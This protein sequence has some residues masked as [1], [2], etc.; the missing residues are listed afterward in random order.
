MTINGNDGNV[1]H[2]SMWFELF[3][4]FYLISKPIIYEREM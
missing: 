1:M 4:G 3:G 2:A